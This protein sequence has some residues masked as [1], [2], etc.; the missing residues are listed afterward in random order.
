[1]FYILLE[2]FLVLYISQPYFVMKIVDKNSRNGF[3]AAF[4]Y[5]DKIMS[6]YLHVP[7][8][9]TCKSYGLCPA[10]L[11][12]IKKSFI[13]FESDNLIIFWKKTSLSAE[14]VLEMRIY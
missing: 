2:G 3:V 11:N 6:Y 1:M 9:E 14:N 5:T 10:G 4:Q 12:M 7:F 13:E 8:L